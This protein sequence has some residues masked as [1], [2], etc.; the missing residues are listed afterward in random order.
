M[1]ELIQEFRIVDKKQL[2]YHKMHGI[3]FQS[4]NIALV[5]AVRNY[6]VKT[7]DKRL[8]W[9][10]QSD[11]GNFIYFECWADLPFLLIDEAL[12]IANHFK[13]PVEL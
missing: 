12:R 6:C 8:Q 2:S 5:N 13:L 1:Y 9:F 11:C 3:T 10:L 4:N 7:L